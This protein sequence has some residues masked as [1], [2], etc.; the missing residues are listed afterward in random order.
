MHYMVVIGVLG[1]GADASANQTARL[2]CHVR[3]RSRDLFIDDDQAT[4][5]FTAASKNPVH[6]NTRT[7]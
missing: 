6:S 4:C 5:F 1:H 2:K 7:E 3:D